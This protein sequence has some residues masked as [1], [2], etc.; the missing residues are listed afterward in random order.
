MHEKVRYVAVM[1]WEYWSQNFGLDEGG[2]EEA[3]DD[4]WGLKHKCKREGRK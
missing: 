1:E 2:T 3:L 4:L